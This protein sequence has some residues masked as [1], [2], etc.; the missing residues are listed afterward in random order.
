MD[1]GEVREGDIV[2]FALDGARDGR[3]FDPPMRI[4]KGQVKNIIW[5]GTTNEYFDVVVMYPDSFELR[6]SRKPLQCFRTAAQ[7]R[8]TARANIHARMEELRDQLSSLGDHSATPTRW[9]P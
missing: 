5:P 9:N 1:H 7:A 6:L 2:Y 3:E 8:S 4:A